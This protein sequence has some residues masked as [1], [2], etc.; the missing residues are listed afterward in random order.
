MASKNVCCSSPECTEP[1]VYKI[2]RPWSD[3]VFNELKSYGLACADHLGPVFKGAQARK[4]DYKPGEAET[5][6]QIGIYKLEPGK[7]DRQL[8][9]LSGLEEN[10]R[11]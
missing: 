8:Q 1:A 10:Y 6:G 5:F 4:K 3:G 7:R 2:A 11:V 9:R